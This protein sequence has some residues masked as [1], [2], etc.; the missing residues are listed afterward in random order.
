MRE[1]LLISFALF[2]SLVVMPASADGDSFAQAYEDTLTVYGN[3]NSDD[4]I[5]EDDIEYVRGSSTEPTRKHSLLMP[6]T[7]VRSMRET[8]LKSS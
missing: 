1:I 2:L 3:A 4:I 8:L 5:D 6:T 7:M